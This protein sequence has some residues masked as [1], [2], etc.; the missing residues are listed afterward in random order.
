M[1]KVNNT[2]TFKNAEISLDDNTIVELLKEEEVTHVL[3]EVLEQ[4]KSVVGDEKRIDITF[5][6]SKDV[7]FN[8]EA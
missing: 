6:E 7:A 2:L 1:A 8:E 3:S 4:F 5:K